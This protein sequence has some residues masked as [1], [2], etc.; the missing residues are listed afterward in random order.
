[1]SPARIAPVL[2]VIALVAGV[3]LDGFGWYSLLFACAAA[4][5]V[6]FPIVR[7][8]ARPPVTTTEQ[9]IE[10]EPFDEAMLAD[11]IADPVVVLDG[12]T[13]VQ[14]NRAARERFGE[15]IAGEDV[16]VAFRHPAFL[17]LI[18]S[19]AVRHAPQSLEL[20]GLGKPGAWWEARTAPLPGDRLIVHLVDRTS[21]RAA[22][23]TRTDFVANASHELRTPL[24]AILGFVETLKDEEGND[25]ELRVRFLGTVQREA[26]RMQRLIEDLLSLSRVESERRAPP[27]SAVSLTALARRV[28]DELS[29]RGLPAGRS[30]GVDADEELADVVGD[31]LQLHQLLMNLVENGLKYGRGDS[32]VV[33]HVSRH[34]DRLAQFRVVDEGEGIAPEHLPRLTERFYR[35]DP[36]RSRRVGGTGLGLAIAKHVVERHRGTMRITSVLGQ[37]TTVTV[38][39]PFARPSPATDA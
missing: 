3:W 7:P 35:V 10:A 19:G 1:M 6:F 29:T 8:T 36:G 5:F 24:S 17:E 15:H 27:D 12:D 33:L 21:E 37:G 18:G 20:T 22:D 13:V 26:E 9:A 39:L 2:L 32:P 23:R 28:A 14:A 11:A 38:R 16:R 34:D 25:P 4:A 31:G 30:I